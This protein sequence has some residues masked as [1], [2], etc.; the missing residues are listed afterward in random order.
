MKFRLELVYPFFIKCCQYTDDL[1]W[2][3]I[4]EDLAYAKSPYG[5]YIT[6]NFLCCNYKDKEFSYKIDSKKDPE[7]IYN[8]I[9][10]LLKNKFGLLSEKDKLIKRKIFNNTNQNA[11]KG[12]TLGWKNIKKKNIKNIIIENYV[13][14]KKKEHNLSNHR[15]KYLLSI[16]MIALIFKNINSNNIE[17]DNGEINT[18]DNITITKKSIY[19]NNIIYNTTKVKPQII[20]KKKKNIYNKWNK[21]LNCL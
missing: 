9:Y 16:I 18:I 17:F 20:I 2:Q 7:V 21:F 4:F 8:E 12:I 13:I 6:K 15:S 19:C 14:K 10:S 5:T 1:F 3:F 11:V